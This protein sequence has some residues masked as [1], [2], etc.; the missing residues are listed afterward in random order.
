MCYNVFQMGLLKCNRVV[1]I[2]RTNRNGRGRKNFHSHNL[3][4]RLY[5]D[6]NV[7]KILPD[8]NTHALRRGVSIIEPTLV[9]AQTQRGRREM[10]GLLQRKSDRLMDMNHGLKVSPVR[11]ESVDV[12]LDNIIHKLI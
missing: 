12:I 5:G 7:T 4:G 11:T 6:R 9:P 3:K 1:D 2:D 8:A 10:V